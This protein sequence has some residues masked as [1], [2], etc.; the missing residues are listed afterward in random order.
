M[1]EI[2]SS[3][4]KEL[5]Y[6]SLNVQEVLVKL[7]KLYSKLLNKWYDEAKELDRIEI[8]IANLRNVRYVHYKMDFNIELSASEINKFLD[9]DTE[10]N[11]LKESLLATRRK[12]ELIEKLMAMV[13]D[14]RWSIKS[15]IEWEK[16]KT[17]S[18]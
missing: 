9:G 13:N 7:P 14:T 4:A 5:D 16:F 8:E 1:N 18:I 11:D 10:L 17:G 12:I 3:M 15:F 6:N 2:I